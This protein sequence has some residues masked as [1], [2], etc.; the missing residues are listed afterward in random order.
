[1]RLWRLVYSFIVSKYSFLSKIKLKMGNKPPPAPPPRRA[2]PG[3]LNPKFNLITQTEL[4]KSLSKKQLSRQ[5]PESRQNRTTK[6][7][8]PPDLSGP[9]NVNLRDPLFEN[10]PEKARQQDWNKGQ[11]SGFSAEKSRPKFTPKP[12]LKSG[13][14]SRL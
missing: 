5:L 3:A 13:G 14:F 10:S 2:P 8:H 1:M 6:E 7:P 4:M 12:P 9:K 11:K